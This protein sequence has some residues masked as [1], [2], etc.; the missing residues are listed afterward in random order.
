MY[1][2][3][4]WLCDQWPLC[5]LPHVTSARKQYC[6][7]PLTMPSAGLKLLHTTI[8]VS[9]HLCI[10]E[11]QLHGGRAT[12][13]MHFHCGC[14]GHTH[15]RLQLYHLPGESVSCR[16]WHRDL[17]ACCHLAAGLSCTPSR[18]LRLWRY[19]SLLAMCWP[20]SN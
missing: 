6:F 18:H 20:L 12:P 9:G 3:G 4:L 17:R 2:P 15:G 16:A 7:V 1:C 14:Q 10:A 19:E 11:L 13:A 8:D 5:L